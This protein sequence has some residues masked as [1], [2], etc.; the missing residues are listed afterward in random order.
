MNKNYDYQLDC[1]SAS[2]NP[3]M[4]S[5][6][7]IRLIREK[8]QSMR[9]SERD[10][11]Y[12][13][14]GDG[15]IIYWDR[16]AETMFGYS[17]EEAIGC[18][19]SLIVPP[20][21]FAL[22]KC[23]IDIMMQTGES[24]FKTDPVDVFVSCKDGSEII[25]EFDP[26]MI[27]AQSEIIFVVVVRDITAKKQD[28]LTTDGVNNNIVELTRKLQQ[29]IIN[30]VEAVGLVLKGA[31][32]LYQEPET[33]MMLRTVAGWNLPE[34]LHELQKQKGT[35]SLDILNCRE[36]GSVLYD[37]LI[38]S[39]FAETDPVV[40]ENA[41]CNCIGR[42]I[43]IEEKSYGV[44]SV[45]FKEKKNFNSFSIK[46]FDVFALAL[47]NTIEHHQLMLR[48]KKNQRKAMIYKEK[49]R[50][51]SSAVL[52]CR[53]LEK[54]N[55]SMALHDELG[56]AVVA[57]STRLSLAEEEIQDQNLDAALEQLSQL[58]IVFNN[59]FEGLKKIVYD[60]RPQEL[61]I[62][63]L[64]A[65]LKVLLSS[66]VDYSVINVCLNY[67]LRGI[68]LKENISIF[69]YRFVKESMSNIIKHAEATKAEISLKTSGK[70]ICLEVR[71]N[72][73]GF[74][75]ESFLNCAG[76]KMGVLGM[77]FRTESLGGT[78]AITSENG[79]QLNIRIPYE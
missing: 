74:D 49:V 7:I 51:L 5:K 68:A 3:C 67:D 52:D 45:Y 12:A 79:T 8:S 40:R 10:S 13:I 69:L 2:L 21:L 54:K 9:H 75:I 61:D 46:I 73:R 71:D 55:L 25:C 30:I 63:G 78:F 60:L 41:I 4:L 11:I 39:T 20:E 47:K 23:K 64:E 53:E 33:H 18:D 27:K 70:D 66:L 59:S 50:R 36:S 24:L 77:R 65:A 43:K 19:Y 76:S 57:V 34:N 6:D 32:A 17:S 28:K 22:N 31:F 1:K 29:N 62:L 38:S 58:K 26:L 16:A 72:G 44:L 14:N 37:D 56:A 35:V 48:Y 42:L 15:V